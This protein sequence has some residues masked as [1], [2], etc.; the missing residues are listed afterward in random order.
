MA[1]AVQTTFALEPSVGYPGLIY[2]SGS[3][4][5]I[6]SCIAQEDIPFGAY[7]RIAGQYCELP[8]SS[9]EVTA[10]GGGVACA[11]SVKAV[12]AGYKAGDIVPVMIQGRVWVTTEEGIANNA[13]PFVRFTPNTGPTRPAGGFLN[14]ADTAKAV[15]PT[16]IKMY[17]GTATAGL[18]VVELGRTGI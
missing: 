16:N 8:D 3:N 11:S 14:S 13:I 9:A 15:Q 5:D 6:V 18:A 1:E 17:R 7:V 12:D 4:H 10:S 2:D